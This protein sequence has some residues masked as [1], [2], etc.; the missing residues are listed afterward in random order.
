MD[1]PRMSLDDDHEITVDDLKEQVEQCRILEVYNRDD[2]DRIS[3]M[4]FKDILGQSLKESLQ[5]D[6]ENAFQQGHYFRKRYMS[7]KDLVGTNGDKIT[8]VDKFIPIVDT[9]TYMA[10]L[11][12]LRYSLC[13]RWYDNVMFEQKLGTLGHKI[14]ILEEIFRELKAIIASKYA[15]PT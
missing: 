13:F 7:C 1:S 10:N 3:G 5:L 6:G 14:D 12:Y 11:E 9:M 15:L 2:A 8:D 4:P